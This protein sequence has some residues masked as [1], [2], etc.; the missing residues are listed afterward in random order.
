LTDVPCVLVTGANRGL[1]L[2]FARQYAA[3][4]WHVIATCRSKQA[5][6]ELRALAGD[7]V[8]EALDVTD[9]RSID[10]LASRLGTPPIDVLLLNAAVHLQRDAK[11]ADLDAARWLEELNVNV[12]APVM[13]ARRLADCVARSAQK[14]IVAI[15]SGSGSIGNVQRGD[16]YAYR[17]GKAA[18]NMAMRVLSLELAPRG[19]TAVPIAPGHTRTNMG[20]SNAPYAVEDSVAKVRAV[21]GVLTPEDSGQFLNRDGS[22]LPW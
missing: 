14:R 7:I 17:S 1:G 3:E 5:A 22:R 20:G 10:A 13:V 9:A 12:V 6:S 16:G 2:E 4:G 19:I 11:L 15:S 8:V 21:I 18:L